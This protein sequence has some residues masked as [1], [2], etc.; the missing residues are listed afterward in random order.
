VPAETN[1]GVLSDAT[2]HSIDRP[3]LTA[4]TGPGTL[5]WRSAQCSANSC[6]EV[7]EL[8][9]GRV[10]IRDGKS[11]DGSPVLKFSGAEWRAFLAGV[12]AGEF[13]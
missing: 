13:D 4:A 8:T 2:A 5:V 9:D 11:G 6:V 1:P 7:A 3:S 10:A 12:K